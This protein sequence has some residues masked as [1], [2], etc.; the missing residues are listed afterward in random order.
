MDSDKFDHIIHAPN[1]LK[2]CASL[3]HVSELEFRVLRE[4]LGVS[5]SVL[6]KQLKVLEEA[7]YVKLKKR[8]DMGR[9]RTWLSLSKKGRKAF[10]EHLDELINLAN[11]TIHPTS[12]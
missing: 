6:S 8:T 10:T 7:S 9:Q 5:E 4:Q 2:I 12:G 11:N 3:A 1:R